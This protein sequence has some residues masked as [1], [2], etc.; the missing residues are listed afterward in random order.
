MEAEYR[1]AIHLYE[2]RGF[3]AEEFPPLPG[4]TWRTIVMSR[5]LTGA[6]TIPWLSMADRPDLCGRV[7]PLAAA[8]VA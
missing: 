4:E 7:A 5:G 2:K 8:K 1:L 6:T 3:T